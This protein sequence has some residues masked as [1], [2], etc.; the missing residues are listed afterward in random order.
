MH[1]TGNNL[2]GLFRKLIHNQTCHYY[3]SSR[4][5]CS[6]LFIKMA[7]RLTQEAV[8]RLE[9]GASPLCCSPPATQSEAAIWAGFAVDDERNAE[10]LCGFEEL[11]SSFA[12]PRISPPAEESPDG[13]ALD[14]VRTT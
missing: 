12:S 8:S 14:D 6:H 11:L 3:K 7:N 13:S 9:Q 4:R 5:H 10:L 1:L 2:I